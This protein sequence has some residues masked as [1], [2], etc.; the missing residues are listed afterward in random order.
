M[1]TFLL[2]IIILAIFWFINSKTEGIKNISCNTKDCK[3]YSHLEAT[4]IC[5]ELCKNQALEYTG[6][7]KIDT[8]QNSCECIES[9]NTIQVPV[10]QI[11]KFADLSVQPLMDLPMDDTNYDKVEEKRLK[12]YSNLIFGNH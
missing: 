4:P 11:E 5:K 2:V 8:Q 1:D 7:Y 12:K 9:L 10:G 6:N 3:I